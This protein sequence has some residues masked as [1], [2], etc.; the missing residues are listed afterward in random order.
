M[1]TEEVMRVGEGE[2]NKPGWLIRVIQNKYPITDFHEVIIHTP[3]CHKDLEVL[4]LSHLEKIFQVYK[5]RF[6][7]YRTK[8]QVIIFCNHRENA[9]A[10]LKHSHSQ[11]VVL[12]NQINLDTLIREPVENL[13]DANHY[14]NVYCPEFS[15]WPYEVWLSSKKQNTY[16]GDITDEEI[17]DLVEIFQNTLKKLEKIHKRYQLTHLPFAYNFYIYP[18]ENWYLR[19]IPRFVNRAG[20]ELGT[21]LSVNI[22]DPKDAAEELKNI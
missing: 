4:S 22:I 6:N 13:V 1:T 15:Q 5:T 9:G 20:F 8:G 17:K 18:K 2:P 7:F 21:G 10:S 19:I 16:F 14:F 12:P 11:L 3:D